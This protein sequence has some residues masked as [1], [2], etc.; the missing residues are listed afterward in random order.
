LTL[1]S[2]DHIALRVRDLAR[3]EAFYCEVLGCEVAARN[4]DAGIVHLRAGQ[5]FIDLVWLEGRMGKQGGADLRTEARNM[6]HFCLNYQAF[7]AQSLF[8][9]LDRHNIEHSAAPQVN[10]GAEGQGM[11]V[12]IADPDENLVELKCYPEAAGKTASSTSEA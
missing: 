2:F 1:R 7:D 6:H 5:Q 10:L 9:F 12:Y 4:G 8:A 11:S 3:S